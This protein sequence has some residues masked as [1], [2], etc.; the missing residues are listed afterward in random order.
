MKRARRILDALHTRIERRGF[1]RQEERR[2][3]ERLV[4]RQAVR[5]VRWA[6]RYG[7]T[8]AV[9]ARRLGIAPTTLTAWV[10][11]WP[12]KE[13]R[14]R[15]RKLDRPDAETRDLVLAVF[16]LM[17]PEVGLPTLRALFPDVSRAELEDLVRRYRHAFRRRTSAVVHALRWSH[18]GSVWAIDFTWPPEPIDGIYE[19]ILVV[20]DLASGAQLA[21]M[22]VHGEDAR[23]VIDLLWALCREYGPPLVLKSDNG[24]GFVAEETRHAL[25]LWDILPLVS[26]PGTPSYNGACEA[27]IGSLKTRAH[28]ESARHDRPGLWTCD[29]VEAARSSANEVLRPWGVASLTPEQTWKIRRPI[30]IEERVRFQAAVARLQPS[31]RE[32]LGLLPDLPLSARQENS[33][34]RVSTSKALIEC[35]YLSIR[36]RRIPLANFPR[37]RTEIS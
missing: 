6:R 1:V 30:S 3:V 5:F 12:W 17:G 32:E 24:S 27:G 14:A 2:A 28:H 34:L 22:P 23:A 19:R 20:R 15:G 8:P 25:A 9:I 36:R 11:T 13:L 21:A 29:D 26:P 18:P 16:G 7:E 35:G 37:R 10:R 31:V 33:M 4:R